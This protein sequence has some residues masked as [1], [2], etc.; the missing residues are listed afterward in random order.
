[1]HQLFGGRYSVVGRYIGTNRLNRFRGQGD[2]DGF[3]DDTI[4]SK[5]VYILFYLDRY[6]RTTQ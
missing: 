2:F 4:H 1:M 6:G 5:I 3:G